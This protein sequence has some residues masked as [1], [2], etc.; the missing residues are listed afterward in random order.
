MDDGDDLAE[1]EDLAARLDAVDRAL[2]RLDD[3]TY[4]SCE[5]CGDAI[6]A[7]ALA[8][9]PT[10]RRCPTHQAGDAN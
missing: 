10:V 7:E 2:E 8:A 1:V 5:V 4:D 6:T 9:D 3:N